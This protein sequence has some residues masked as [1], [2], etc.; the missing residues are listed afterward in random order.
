[1][2]GKLTLQEIESVLYAQLVGRIGCHADGETYVVPISYVYDGEYII[3]HTQ[4]GKKIRM[5]RENPRVCFQLDDV[6]DLGHWKSV[7]VQGL[8]EEVTDADARNEAMRKLLERYLPL[9]TSS[10][11]HLGEHWPFH[12]ENFAEIGGQVFRIQVRERSGRYERETLSPSLQ[13]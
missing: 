7:I 13:G 4:E 12:P 1:M 6:T 9:L 11:M 5:M 10:T 2:L 8:F 3:C